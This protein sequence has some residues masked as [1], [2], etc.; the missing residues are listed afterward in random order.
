MKENA[1]RAIHE[2][3]INNQRKQ[4][5][6][7]IDSYGTYDFWS[8]YKFFLFELYADAIAVNEFFTDATISYFRI[9]GR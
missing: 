3:L 5:I 8:D 1:I 6:R 9:K 7:Q 2:S 4:M